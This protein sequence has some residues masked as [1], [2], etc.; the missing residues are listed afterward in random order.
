MT[1]I[2][3]IPY[4]EHSR[5]ISRKILSPIQTV[6]PQEVWKILSAHF[7]DFT[8]V[9]LASSFMSTMFN[10][11]VKNLLVTRDLNSIFNEAS[12]FKLA[13]ALMPL[14][15]FTY[16][17]TSY[18]LNH[19]QTPGMLLVKKRMEMKASNVRDAFSWA[20]HSFL[21]CATGGISYSL[22]KSL[23][24]AFKDHDYLYSEL[25]VHKDH[26]VMD[27]IVKI[28]SFQEEDIQEDWSKA[29]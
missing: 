27:L 11:S 18:F 16:F 2:D 20:T 13:M 10:L 22:K 8:M 25:L 23:W 28:E 5:K 29:A 21:L 19:G 4:A 9:F 3:L 1:P 26:V 7:F 24:Q 15:L 17:F 12:T 6:K 14:T